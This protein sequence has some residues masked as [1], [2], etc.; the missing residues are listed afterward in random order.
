MIDIKTYYHLLPKKYPKILPFIFFAVVFV[1]AF[2]TA[3][4]LPHSKNF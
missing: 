2:A 1:S 4:F 3:F